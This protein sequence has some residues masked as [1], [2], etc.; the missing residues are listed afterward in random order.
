MIV[1]NYTPED[2]KKLPLRAI[3]A[4]AARCAR[5]VE[6]LALLPEDHPESERC[7]AAVASAIRLA[8]DFAK[9][10]PCSSLE[11]VVRGGRGVSGCRGERFR[12]RQRD[13]R[14]RRWRPTRRRPRIDSLDLRCE[15]GGIAHGRSRQ[16]RS[17]APPGGCDGRPGCAG[18]L[19][20]GP[21]SGGAGRARRRNSSSAAV[22]DYEKLL[23]A[24]PR[25]LS[26]GRKADRP[27]V[28]GTARAAGAYA[29]AETIA[30]ATASTSPA[31]MATSRARGLERRQLISAPSGGQRLSPRCRSGYDGRIDPLPGA[32]WVEEE[33]AYNFS[34]YAQ[35]AESVMLLLFGRG[36]RRSVLS[37]NI[38]W[39]PG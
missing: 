19:H 9:G 11:S 30:R 13:G 36:R 16:A 39:I 24:R 23:A 32:A 34:L 14:R 1:T 3:V 10:S 5:R 6:H 27:L 37:S 26:T 20:G 33:H 38:G 18:R 21:G 22:G 8:E 25:Q 4:L 15:H 17:P 29:S 28:E 7:R 12:A 35:H 31:I 2:L